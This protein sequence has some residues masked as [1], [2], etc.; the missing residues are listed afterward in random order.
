MYCVLAHAS[1]GH[2]CSPCACLHP[3][4][5]TQVRCTQSGR[6]PVSRKTASRARHVTARFHKL[7]HELESLKQKQE[8]GQ[9][10]AAQSDNATGKGG[11][12]KKNKKSSKQPQQQQQQSSASSSRRIREIEALLEEMGGRK[13]YQDASIIN[14]QVQ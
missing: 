5:L 7:T 13:A 14:T 4:S 8:P 2:V 12:K 6:L 3:P 11:S 1:P 9:E 10:G